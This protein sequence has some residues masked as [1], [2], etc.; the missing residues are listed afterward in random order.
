MPRVLVGF[1][2]HRIG[3]MW[4]CDPSGVNVRALK[5]SHHS[6]DSFQYLFVSVGLKIGSNCVRLRY[7]GGVGP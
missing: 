5:L 1:E 6:V 7:S 2:R 4:C 3:V